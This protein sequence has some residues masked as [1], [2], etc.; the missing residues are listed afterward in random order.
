MST[1]IEEKGRT[2]SHNLL[3]N[4]MDTIISFSQPN[5][6]LRTLILFSLPLLSYRFSFKIADWTKATWRFYR[7]DPKVRGFP[8]HPHGWF[9]FVG[10]RNPPY[11]V[12]KVLS[13]RI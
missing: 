8:S 7:K 3:K 1:F 13:T 11:Q 2:I 6:E 9:G 5:V 4:T 12:G 10:E